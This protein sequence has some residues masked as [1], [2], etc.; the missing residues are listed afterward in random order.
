[1]GIIFLF[2]KSRSRFKGDWRLFGQ[3]YLSV[4]LCLTAMLLGAV[5]RGDEKET[6][7]E[8]SLV[9]EMRLGKVVF[10]I[11]LCD[12]AG[13]S[14][15]WTEAGEAKAI[16]VIFL[17]FNCPVSNRYL[18]VLNDLVAHSE[19]QGVV[20]VAVVCDAVDAAEVDRKV[21]EFQI[22]CRVFYDPEKLV[23]K[24][25][26]ASITPQV[27]L[28]DKTRVLRYFGLIDSQY[29][30][31]LVRLQTADSTYLADAIGAVVT[32]RKVDIQQTKAIGCPLDPVDKPIVEHG[33]VEFHRDIEPLLQ[34]HCQRCHH[35][36][37][38]APFSLVTFENAIQWAGDIKKYTAE[39]LMPPWSVTGG[40]PLKNNLALTS[41]EIELIG[42]WVDEGSPRGN[43]ADAPTPMVFIDQE[44]WDDPRPPDLVF[45]IPDTFHIAAKGEEHYRMICFPM[46]NAEELY[47][48]KAQF[49]PG[50]RQSIHH[51]MVFYD[52][53]GLVLD[54]QTRLGNAF[55]KGTDDEDYGPGYNSGMG[56]GFIPDPTKKYNNSDNP[57]GQLY[58]WVPGV[59]P[60]EYPDGARRLIPPH[61][62][63]SMQIH[64]SRTGKPEI[65]DSSRLGLWIDKKK[66]RM[67]SGGFMIDTT[68]LMIPKDVSHFKATG[69]QVVPSD[70]HLWLMA[71][72]MHR[73]GKEFRIWHQAVG[74]SERKLLLELKNWDFDWQCRY[75]PKEPYLM[76]KGST[77]HVEAIFDNS[78]GNPLRQPGP[79]KAI[80]VGEETSDEMAFALIGTITE[81]RPKNKTPFMVKYL[82]KLIKAKAYRKAY[83]LLDF[84]N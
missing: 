8:D 39:R 64:Y 53:T 48:E 79:A 56:L 25:F 12:T 43:P 80:F 29:A 35:P 59:G 71:P 81:Q 4:G 45:K 7:L 77:M 6:S 9:A 10:P 46:N 13:N 70:C 58:G 49:I 31:R 54:A 27:F 74:S 82:E 2:L 84:E 23:A 38:V 55:P 17:N 18:S 52:G 26:L 42:R 83:E 14:W 51:G 60:L 41:A 68:F 69:L 5:V 62:S 11:D 63:I 20:F 15:S 24:H 65:D 73:L 28:L 22:R 19:E 3:P 1:M 47:L 32:G 30:S 37:D 50:N 78:A 67:Y 76:K 57:G 21:A 72:H 40:I 34:Q 66:P 44:A 75:A 16:A 36:G 33:S 61:S